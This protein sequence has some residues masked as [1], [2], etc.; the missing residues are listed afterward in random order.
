MSFYCQECGYRSLKWLGRCPSCGS[1]DTFVEEKEVLSPKKNKPRSLPKIYK[2]S[3]VIAQKK[4]RILTGLS[5][6]DLVLGGGIV[7]SSFLLIGGA[8]GIGKSTLLIQ[9]ASILSSKGFKVLY[10]SAEE[11]AEQVKLR[12]ERLE[13]NLDFYFCSENNLSLLP[14]L[15]D[16]IE[17][18]FLFVD[19]IQ[20]VY[21]EEIVSS[22]GSVS[23]VRECANFLMRVAKERGLTVWTIGHITKEGLIAG[24]KVLEHLVDVVLYLEGERENDLRILRAVKNRFGPVNEVGVLAMTQ[25][26]LVS[27]E[28]YEDLFL[29][30]KDGAVF[31]ALEGTRPLLVEVQA[32]AVKSFLAIPRRQAVGLEAVR[33][34][35]LCAIL[36]KTANLPLRDQDIFVKVACGL[37]L[38]DP[39]SDLAVAVA[40]I[41]SFLDKPLPLKALYLG[42][43]GLKGEI[44]P[45]VNLLSRL[46]EAEKKGFKEVYLAHHP[47]LK[48]NTQLRIHQIS[49]LNQLLKELFSHELP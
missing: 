23:Q 28:E 37:Q 26:G 2:L 48:L 49:H 34:S 43:I 25:K 41:S 21:L 10:L 22:P 18:H 20:T 1:Y 33:L 6:L 17:P 27:H 5:E 14:S 38:R 30:N 24:P 11:S 35:L 4:E 40:I 32:L 8:P 16:E 15:L 12:A 3:E 19:S 9:L 46:K 7:P 47:N 44:K 36:E 39:A 45:V 31:C 42:E 13:A 29:P